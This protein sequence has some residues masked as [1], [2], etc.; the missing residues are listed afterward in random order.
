MATAKK[1]TARKRPTPQPKPP[2]ADVKVI[3]ITSNRAARRKKNGPGPRVK[4][5]TL[6]YELPARPPLGIMVALGELQAGNMTGIG[7]LFAVL[8]GEGWKDNPAVLELED[9]D[10]LE[11]LDEAWDLSLG[12]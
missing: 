1:T 11:L 2:A 9:D 6:V 7:S 10:L 12:K 5:G 4:V 3:D 8:F